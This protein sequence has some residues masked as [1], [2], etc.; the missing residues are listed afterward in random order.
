MK[1]RALCRIL[2][3]FDVNDRYYLP[4]LIGDK[5]FLGA[6]DDDFIL[7]GYTVRHFRDVTKAQTKNDMYNKILKKEGVIDDIAIPDITIT[8]WETI[9]KSLQKTNKNIIVEK[10][11]LNNEECEFT[12]GRIEKIY[13]H[14][15]YIRH[16]DADGIWQ[17]EP[18]KITY[19]GI[20]SVTFDSRYITIYSKYLS[21]LPEGFGR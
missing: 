3:R 16:F 19:A 13:K 5:L 12:I 8:N 20:T 4:L 10:E 7:D 11:S 1:D 9:F 14:F 15:A 17:N 18:R 6:E 21:D 2:L